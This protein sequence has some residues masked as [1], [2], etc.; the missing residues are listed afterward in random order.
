MAS[1]D[2]HVVMR[3]SDKVIC[4]NGHVCC[5]GTPEAVAAAPAYRAFLGEPGDGT[6]AL[7]RHDHD[8]AHDHAAHAEV[9]SS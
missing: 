3:Q 5:S 6:L 1:H 4:L 9:P 2:L 7:Y 8:H